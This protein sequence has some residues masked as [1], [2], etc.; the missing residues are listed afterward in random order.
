MQDDKRE[1]CTDLVCDVREMGSCYFYGCNAILH[2][3]CRSGCFRTA[4][5][6]STSNSDAPFLS[7]ESTIISVDSTTQ[8]AEL[9]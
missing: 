3:L 7:R 6:S 2:S 4:S 5:S 8:C 1:K 9:F